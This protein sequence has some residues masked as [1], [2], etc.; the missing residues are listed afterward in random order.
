MV[1][2]TSF[3]RY[4]F[5]GVGSQRCSGND[6]DPTYCEDYDYFG[7]YTNQNFKFQKFTNQKSYIACKRNIFYK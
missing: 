6:L 2:A 3:D 1:P 7:V 5:Y 4:D